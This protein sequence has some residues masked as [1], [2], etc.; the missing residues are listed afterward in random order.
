MYEFKYESERKEKKYKLYLFLFIITVLINTFIDIFDLEIE[1]VSGFR[2]VSSL[3]FFGIILYFGLRRK[4][5]AEFMIKFF[6]WLN[7]ILLFIIITVKV[8]GL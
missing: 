2:I 8:L 3:L 4:L 6:V 7:I 5:W 1:K